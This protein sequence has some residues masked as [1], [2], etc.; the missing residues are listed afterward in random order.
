MGISILLTATQS[1]KSENLDGYIYI[2]N[3]AW[4]LHIRFDNTYGTGISPGVA[5]IYNFEFTIELNDNYVWNAT[6]ATMGDFT[7]TREGDTWYSNQHPNMPDYAGFNLTFPIADLVAPAVVTSSISYN[8]DGGTAGSSAP[9]SYDS[10]DS[11]QNITIPEP[12][13]TG[14]NFTGWTV[15]WNGSGNTPTIS[16]GT[17]SIPANTTGD[18]TLTAGWSAATYTIS[19]D[20]N[21]GSTPSNIT[22]TYGSTYGTLPTPTRDYYTFTG[23]H[24]GS[25]T[26]EL[27]TSS[28]TVSIAENH[29][30]YAS[31]QVMQFNVTFTSNN[32]ALGT[33][34]NEMNSTPQNALGSYSSTA[35]ASSVFSNFL[36]WTDENGTIITTNPT[37]TIE[38]L[39]ENTIRIAVFSAI[40]TAVAASEGGEVRAN[41]TTIDGVDYIHVSALCALNYDFIGWSTSDGT[42]LSAYGKSADIPLSLVEG[43]LIIANFELISNTNIND[44][45][46]TENDFV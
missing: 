3:G 40:G 31:W 26:G 23:W 45:T 29:T 42:D 14:Y 13:K 37:C 25:P 35:V 2:D 27:I 5:N 24:L 20:G 38:S 43:K 12:T 32:S 7:L 1:A 6:T 30:L 9:T 41:Y 8:L 15:S 17:L 22:V 39:T 34:T 4:W 46:N 16:N 10:A 28:S 44:N 21:G 33:V 36:Y 11:L 19:F 18:I